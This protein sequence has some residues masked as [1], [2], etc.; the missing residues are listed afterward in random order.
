MPRAVRHVIPAAP[1]P[2]NPERDPQLVAG[3]WHPLAYLSGLRFYSDS[4][5]KQRLVVVGAWSDD[6]VLLKD[7]SSSFCRTATPA[8]V[9]SMVDE[10]GLD[11]NDEAL[12]EPVD[13]ARLMR[14]Q[15]ITMPR[16]DA[17]ALL[18]EAEQAEVARLELRGLMQ[19]QPESVDGDQLPA[20][21]DPWL[22]G[23]EDF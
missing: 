14:A 22:P 15:S 8:W 20:D 23:F 11:E 3:T 1:I 9:R 12:S 13:W 2:V 4:R 19:G 6:E 5:R 7:V 16:S 18:K 21:V 10:Y 17:E